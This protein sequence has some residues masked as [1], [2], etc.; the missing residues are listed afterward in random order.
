MKNI[1]SIL[2][3]SVI[4]CNLFCSCK[5]ATIDS[6][7]LNIS[8]IKQE[9]IND[10]DQQAY[11]IFLDVSAN[12]SL[13]YEALSF[14]ILL[15]NQKNGQANLMVFVQMIEIFNK[16]KFFVKDFEN[17]SEINKHY[18]LH[19]LQEAASLQNTRGQLYLEEIYRRG[20]GVEK[21]EKKADSIHKVL[22]KSKTYKEEYKFAYPELRR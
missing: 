13:N 4:A 8:T 5:K 16:K 14:S 1:K 7:K 20:I 9:I 17:L 22:L 6:K 21:N 10:R 2:L 12:D 19:H 3:I 15:A 11:G 18:A